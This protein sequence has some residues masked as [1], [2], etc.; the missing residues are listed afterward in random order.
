MGLDL[1]ELKM[2]NFEIK[3]FGAHLKV[4]VVEVIGF[5]NKTHF[6]GGFYCKLNIEIKVED[7]LLNSFFYATTQNLLELRSSLKKCYELIDGKV[8]FFHRDSNLELTLIFL[9]NG[10]IH[11]FGRFQK[12]LSTDNTLNFEFYSD[13][14]YIYQTLEQMDFLNKYKI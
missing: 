7:I 14:T 10:G 1:F 6:D 12:Y 13:Q 2:D 9:K 3:G 11:I 4:E 5:P 8:D